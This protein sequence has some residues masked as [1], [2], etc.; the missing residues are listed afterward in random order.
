MREEG[1]VKLITS[2][3]DLAKLK[4]APLD[5]PLHMTNVKGR[6]EEV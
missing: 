2:G 1:L 6:K 3:A 5:L 4:G